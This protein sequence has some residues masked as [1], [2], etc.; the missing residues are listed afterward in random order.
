MKTDGA[1]DRMSFGERQISFVRRIPNMYYSCFRTKTLFIKILS[2][3]FSC[4]KSR[5]TLQ[6]NLFH[7]Q[8]TLC[9][10]ELQSILICIYIYICIRLT[11]IR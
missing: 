1:R 2:E 3:Q 8:Y 6:Y 7:S 9:I 10:N 5:H 4:L 11:Y